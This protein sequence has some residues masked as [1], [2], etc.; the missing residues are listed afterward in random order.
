MNIFSSKKNQKRRIS[1]KAQA[2]LEFVLILPILMLVLV[3][4]LEFG[5][6]FYAWLIIENS[7]RFGIRYATA[8][9]YDVNECIDLSSDADTIAC[10]GDSELEE[11]KEARL[12]SIKTEIRRMVIGFHKDE[13]LAWNANDYL[14]ITV[15]SDAT[16]FTL[17]LI[18]I[19][20]PTRPY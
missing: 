15:C 16:A 11:I 20:E 6:L 10:G 3:G 18:H 2:L 4:I 19:S 17:S 8:G 1:K 9:T 5:R 14:K 12:P 7:T 13:T